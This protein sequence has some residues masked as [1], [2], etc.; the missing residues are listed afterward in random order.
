M[1]YYM[2]YNDDCKTAKIFQHHQPQD[3]TEEI[4]GLSNN[5]STTIAVVN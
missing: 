5:D 3:T 4:Y 2:I 1:L